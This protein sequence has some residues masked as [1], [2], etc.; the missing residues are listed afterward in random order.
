MLTNKLRLE[1]AVLDKWTNDLEK[2]MSYIYSIG[3]VIWNATPNKRE[4]DFL[5]S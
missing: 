4:I 2:R 5:E 3:H 1:I